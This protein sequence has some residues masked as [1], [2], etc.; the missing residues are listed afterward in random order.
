MNRISLIITMLFTTVMVGFA[1]PSA[2]KKVANS[3]FKLTTYNSNGSVKYEGVGVYVSPD[4]MAISTWS[5]F[6]NA[7]KATIT[8]PKGKQY[9]VETI[10]GANE[11]YDVCKFRVAT[12]SKPAKIADTPVSTGNEVWAVNDDRRKPKLMPFKVDRTENFDKSF[13]YYIVTTDDTS[14]I[15]GNPLIDE[16]GQLIGL[17]QKSDASNEIHATDARFVNGLKVDG[18]DINNS[19]FRQTGIRL[20]LPSEKEQALIMLVLSGQQ[21]DSLRHSLYVEDFIRKFPTE[22]DGY[23]ARATEKVDRGDFDGAD[24]DLQL[25]IKNAKDKAE[26]HSEYSRIMYQKIIYNPDT[27]YTAW[28]LD[29]ALDETRKAYSINPLPA[30]K[31]REAQIIFSQKD[32]AKA[33]DMFIALAKAPQRTGEYFFE[34]AQ[35][36]AQ[37]KAP[38]NEIIALLDSAVAACPQPLTNIAAPYV[39]TRGEAYDAAGEYKKAIADYNL[40]DTLMAGRGNDTFYYTKFKCEVKLK[41]YQQALNDIAHAAIL[42]PQQ[43]AYLA[44][45]ASLQLR[46]NRLDDAIRTADLCIRVAPDE[47]DAYIIKGLALILDKQKAEG[48]K[49]LGKAKQLGDERAQGL[50]DKYSK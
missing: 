11:L 26:A 46:V 18:M 43:P 20:E 3:T 45:M 7:A 10:V 15:A 36:K 8:D 16:K 2:V 13:T 31:H 21:T 12:S 23:S 4:G 37:L 34:A 38:N 40:Y 27:T 44:E 29:K 48:L 5:P 24:K 39:L 14:R 28:T 9:N 33:Y 19:L 25:S 1:Q 22:V 41:Q 47:S 42:N 17:L 35:C 50:I 6:V 32:Y 30:Y 49:C